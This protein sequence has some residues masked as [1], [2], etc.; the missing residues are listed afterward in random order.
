MTSLLIDTHVLLWFLENSSQLKKTISSLILEASEVYV[1]SISIMEIS[2]KSALGKMH[3]PQYYLELMKNKNLKELNITYTH[4]TRVS[5]LPLIH[6]DPFDRLLVAQ[7]MCE[8]L[9]IVTRDAHIPLY[10]VTTIIA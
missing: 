5:S 4:A 7:A 6:K 1:S 10:P 3:I 9:T 8:N 2:I